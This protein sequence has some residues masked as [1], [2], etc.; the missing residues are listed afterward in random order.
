[1]AR[2]ASSKLHHYLPQGYLRGFATDENH[3]RVRPLDKAR[4]SFTANVR[5]VGAR[6]HFN[7]LEDALEPDGFEK[8]LSQLEGSAI[9]IMRRLVSGELPIPEED[10]EL[11]AYFVALQAVRGPETRRNLDQLRAHMV[12]AEIGMGGRN[13]VSKWVKRHLGVEPTAEEAERIW[14]E[15]VQ[16][17]GPPVKFS[18]HWQ[19]EHM[20]GM[21]DEI[22]PYIQMRP[23]SV[24]HFEKRA[25]LVSDAPVS[26]VSR[27]DEGTFMGVGFMT[28][29]G[30]TFPLSRRCGLLMSD[31]LPMVD[32]RS[33]DEVNE[34]R[35]AI[36]AGKAD[37]RV[38]GSTKLARFFNLNSVFNAQEYIY[39]H[40]D[41][42]AVIP[43]AL[44]EP[45][46]TSMNAD[47]FSDWEFD[48]T[49]CFEGAQE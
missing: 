16:Q 44:P 28:A 3:I 20:L 11:L 48:G 21:A 30:I 7:T 42:E 15:A 14:D 31:P 13:N 40:P 4:P 27:E 24:V 1:M 29:W 8:D 36:A 49:P 37:E 38:A 41:D 17:G 32:G 18:N 12:R 22:L 47:V 34:I 45:R 19:I 43:S 6:S 46:L 26:L 33:E 5:N 23:W 10:R 35:Q 2:G 9:A 25:L 39:C